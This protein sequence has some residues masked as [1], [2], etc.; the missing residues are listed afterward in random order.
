MSLPTPTYHWDADGDANGVGDV[1]AL[2]G[3][4]NLAWLGG[5]P[6]Y[7]E[8]PPLA[9]GGLSFVTDETGNQALY[10][11]GIKL[12]DSADVGLSV[13]C[14]LYPTAL[15]EDHIFVSDFSGA[16]GG[17][18]FRLKADGSME[19]ALRTGGVANGT[20]LTFSTT[21][22]GAFV[23]NQWQF[24]AATID[25]QQGGF[26]PDEEVTVRVYRNAVGAVGLFGPQPNN[27]A[28]TPGVYVGSSPHS[29]L[30]NFRGRIGDVRIW[31]DTVLSPSQVAELAAGPVSTTDPSFI[32]AARPAFRNPFAPA[33]R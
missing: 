24:F 14:W 15:V 19:V 4:V 28:G 27:T 16:T 23:V 32:A 6:T 26:L 25:Y 1:V 8:R 21:G 5:T 11:S 17:A 3:G 30:A 13:A 33:F 31:R 10:A 29:N 22:V 12:S 2:Q 9:F 20:A 18:A 7:A